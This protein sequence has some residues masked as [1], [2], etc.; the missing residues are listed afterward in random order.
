MPR[1]KNEES[2]AYYYLIGSEIAGKLSNG[3]TLT[4]SDL[5][6][7]F[8]AIDE[9]ADSTSLPKKI[10]RFFDILSPVFKREDVGNRDFKV[11][12]VDSSITV[13]D[14][15]KAIDD[16][17]CYRFKIKKGAK[18]QQVKKVAGT[19]KTI[20]APNMK[21]ASARLIGKI[22]NFFVRRKVTAIRSN[23]YY[24]MTRQEGVSGCTLSIKRA[25]RF[26]NTVSSVTG[27]PV[28]WNYINIPE[29]GRYLTIDGSNEEIKAIY[30]KWVE[31]VKTRFGIDL[32]VDKNNAIV[33]R[34]R[35][36]PPVIAEVTTTTPEKEISYSD[37]E[38]YVLWLTA[39][40][41]QDRGKLDADVFL[42]TLRAKILESRV[43]KI[44]SRVE[45]QTLLRKEKI[46]EIG[47][48]GLICVNNV[49]RAVQVLE[50]Y[51]PKK[52]TSRV[53]VV[54]DIRGIKSFLNL[55]GKNLTFEEKHTSEKRDF[56]I[57][58]IVFNYTYSSMILYA[59]LLSYLDEEGKVLDSQ[60][61]WMNPKD[62]TIKYITDNVDKFVNFYDP[63]P[64]F[65]DQYSGEIQS[66]EK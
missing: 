6:K 61:D 39:K 17:L 51:D 10:G 55:W 9:K 18:K 16:A 36:T 7:V 45:Y 43:K 50:R 57:Y 2:R 12:F 52:I 42:T 8:K 19:K 32:P 60:F 46:F 1:K 15:A 65:K 23:E 53:K 31:F 25:E 49:E 26:S 5:T 64:Y 28:K 58:E 38:K 4:K 29:D 20:V 27:L 47:R 13:E 22:L 63:V 21:V 41:L 11:V 24:T 33:E 44:N 3:Q 59:I 14:A 66:W 48:N 40:T 34:P 56:A 35:V 37:E 54:S 30:L 62:P